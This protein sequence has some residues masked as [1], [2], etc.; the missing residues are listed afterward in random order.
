MTA[1]LEG[2]KVLDM[3]GPG[4]ACLVT[5]LMGDMG[6]EIIKIDLPPNAGNRGVGDGI[7]FGPTDPLEMAKLAANTSPGRN[8]EY[9]SINLRLEA[10]QKVFHK[11]AETADVV[12]E[13]FRPGVMDRM[14][15]GYAALSKINPRIIYCAAS[16][17][18]QTGPYSRFP[19]HDANYAGMGG[20]QDLIGLSP[21]E[22][23]VF[24]QNVIADLAVAYEQSVIGI[25]L[26]LLARERTGRGQ[27]VDVSMMDGVVSL[28]AGLPE[29]VTYFY[30]GS[31]P[32]RGESSLSGTH[33]YYAPYKTKD[34]KW[35]T[36]CTLEPKFW[37]NLCRAI[38]RED[39]IPLQYD[40]AKNDYLLAE[41]RKIFV[42]K[43][44][45]EWFKL[46][47]AADVPAGKIM[48]MEDVVKDPHVL[49]RQMVMEVDDPRFG[50]VKQ[51]GFPIKL[52][53]TPGTIRS[54]AR[55]LGEDT[56]KVMLA[57]GFSQSEI[58]NLMKQG[59]IYQG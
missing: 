59:V 7:A 50:K 41:L 12:I 34:E 37:A 51:I 9:V 33:P 28:T 30:S 29:A 44:Q 18:G 49:H 26:A 35:L 2:I 8:K 6:A 46:L 15:C 53:D 31:V 21:D 25:L 23:P 13:A 20:V 39:F 47:T 54:L 58:D 32:K 24:A 22:A 52:S 4:P 14:N 36:I 1:A 11:L 40:P 27:M 10:G 38:E 17:Y 45:D 16:G 5:M 19:G 43:T 56:N 48:P 55:L 42:T 57:H 3:T